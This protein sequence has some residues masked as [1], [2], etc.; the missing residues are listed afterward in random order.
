[1]ELEFTVL[2]AARILGVHPESVKRWIR[3]GELQATKHGILYYIKRSDLESFQLLREEAQELRKTDP[4]AFWSTPQGEFIAKVGEQLDGILADQPLGIL[5][6]EPGGACFAGLFARYRA[7]KKGQQPA[8]ISLN[9]LD[10]HMLE[11]QLRAAREL[12]RGRKLLIVD[13][14]SHD[15][16][17]YRTVTNLCFR[18]AGLLGFEDFFIRDLGEYF[19][20]II[21]PFL[22]GQ[23]KGF[24]T[25]QTA[26]RIPLAVHTDH[27]AI[28]SFFVRRPPKE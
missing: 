6:L 12:L 27:V 14:E 4:R 10:P 5:A 13:D 19:E 11:E 21:A 3:Y 23:I 22:T 17:A 15:G 24:D 7:V 16:T 2:E 20:I 8:I 28:A 25:I 18:L 1:M 26:R 9:V